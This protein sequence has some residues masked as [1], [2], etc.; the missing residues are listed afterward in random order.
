MLR[1][2]VSGGRGW[3][4]WWLLVKILVDNIQVRLMLTRRYREYFILTRH[5][6]LCSNTSEETTG[7][8][9]FACEL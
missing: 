5:H 7:A 3:L 2:L 1:G 9:Y 6:Q 8:S 4:G